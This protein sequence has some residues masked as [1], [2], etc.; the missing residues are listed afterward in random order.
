MQFF[1]FL[2]TGFL[3]LLNLFYPNTCLTCNRLLLENE[4]L[5]CHHC[6]SKMPFTNFHSGK[7]NLLYERLSVVFPIQY[8]TALLLFHKEG[9][10]QELI[11]Q[12]KYQNRQDIGRWLAFWVIN[13]NYTF[14]NNNCIDYIIP[15]PLH[16]KKF[17]KRG[18][19]QLTLF[20]ETISRH[21]Q[22]SYRENIL[23]RTV[24]T[25]SQTKKST[26]ERRKNVTGVFQVRQPELYTGKHF[27]I[28]DDV[29][30]TGATIEACAETILKHIPGAK[31][32]VLSMAMVL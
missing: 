32:S 9:L 13:N 17:K 5:I 3:D 27:L 26:I 4:N 28:V 7:D 14:L 12:L 21:Y 25:S 29:I 16:P 2:K 10:T 6:L 15:V 30:T 23:L 22:I 1:K 11:H 20:G 31:I 19:N 24:N 8:A 18:Y